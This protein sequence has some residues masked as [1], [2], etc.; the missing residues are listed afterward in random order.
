MNHKYDEKFFHDIVWKRFIRMP[1]GHLLDYAGK[2]GEAYYPT[3]E[4]CKKCM[5]NSL[6]W[7][8]PIENGAFFTGLY[9]Y[10][11]IEKYH[12]SKDK[13]TAEEVNIRKT[14]FLCQ[15]SMKRS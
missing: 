14:S 6:G 2:S 1:Y 10:A 12:K 9:T 13:K 7:W 3:A 8:T 11:L 4:E 5:P 15:M